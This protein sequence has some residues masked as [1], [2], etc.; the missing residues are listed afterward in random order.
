VLAFLI[1]A[2]VAPTQRPPRST[3]SD[4]VDSGG[5][6]SVPPPP[7]LPMNVAL[8]TVDTL[9]FDHTSLG[10]YERDT[11]PH[12]AALAKESVVFTHAYS[13]AGWTKPSFASTFTS[14]EPHVHG[15]EDWEFT[16]APKLETVAQTLKRAGYHT[17]A[18]V[19]SY[20]VR[21][22][23]NDFDRGFDV[24]D[25][26]TIDGQDSHV[27]ITGTALTDLTLASLPGLKEPWFVW[28][29]YTDPH[30]DYM[31]Q[32]DHVFGKLAVDLYDGEIAYEDEQLGRL[33]EAF[34][35][36]DTITIFHADHGEE[37]Y[38]HGGTYH[39]WTLYD[40]LV[41]VPLAVRIPGVAP[42]VA[43]NVVRLIDVA[44]TILAA[45]DLEP[46]AT[47]QGQPLVVGAADLPVAME[48]R[49]WATIS[50]IV[51]WPYK[52]ILNL[53]A[54]DLSVVSTELYDLAQDPGETKDLSGALPD[55]VAKMRPLVEASI[56]K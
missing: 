19:T 30:N 41:R 13:H 1:V 31:E 25:S 37:F 16:F 49:R 9:R 56:S 33:F 55:V 17:A 11:T 47:F 44:P 4:S 2:C 3:A 35:R 12:L 26:T 15:L 22:A 45:V 50:A 24:F 23:D 54:K 20:A 42:A 18:Y 36:D 29:H 32:P 46:P 8:V 14:T 7:A 39:T 21:A 51:V 48:A 6:E 5:T 43:T 40:E 10:A 38:D 27:A 52:L 34:D 53:E 28:V